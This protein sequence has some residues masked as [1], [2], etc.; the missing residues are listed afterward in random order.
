MLYIIG[1]VQGCYKELQHLLDVV[2]YNPNKDRLGFVG[3]LVNR[4]PQSLE[5]LRF[6]KSL[7]NPLVVLGN[8]DLHLCAMAEDIVPR[9]SDSSLNAILDA[10]DKDELMTWLR[11]QP[12]IHYDSDNNFLALHAGVPPQWTIEQA[13]SYAREVENELRNKN[14]KAFLSKMH[15]NEPSEWN[16]NLTGADRLRYIVNA[17]TRIRFCT[18]DGKLDLTNKTDTPTNPKYKPWF[19]WRENDNVDIIFGHWASL[20][21]RCNKPG[22]YALDTGCVWGNKLTALRVEDKR[23]FSYSCK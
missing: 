14:F 20:E 16:E 4:G 22:F 8:H 23:L 15:G 21:G 2:D 13:V 6:I 11:Q 19:E 18:A 1:D 17:L 12:L 5:T 10:P 7:N 3:D 9:N